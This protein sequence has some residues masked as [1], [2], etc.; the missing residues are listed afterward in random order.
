MYEGVRKNVGSAVP[1]CVSV[2]DEISPLCCEGKLLTPFKTGRHSL[3]G[4]QFRQKER[5][6]KAR[7]LRQGAIV[8]KIDHSGADRF[9]VSPFF[10]K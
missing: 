6:G 10:A 5:G 4:G 7:V 1:D 3:P 9:A 2:E 8:K